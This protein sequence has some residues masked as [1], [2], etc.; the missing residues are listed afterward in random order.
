MMNNIDLAHEY[1]KIIFL[2]KD[3]ERFIKLLTDDCKFNTSFH[4]FQYSE[5]YIDS[6][7]YDFPHGFNYKIIKSFED[8]NSA[9]LIYEF[10]KS[11]ISTIMAQLVEVSRDKMSSIRLIFD[12]KPFL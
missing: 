3:I 6:L 7:I 2:G 8:N 4:R 9:C 1:L 12:T 5:A 10:S 11:G